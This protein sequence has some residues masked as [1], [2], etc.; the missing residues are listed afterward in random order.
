MMRGTI[1]DI[2]H[3]LPPRFFWCPLPEL[4]VLLFEGLAHL[5][6]R[7]YLHINDNLRPVV[8]GVPSKLHEV[9]LQP[10]TRNTP[11]ALPLVGPLVLGSDDLITGRSGRL[12]VFP[13]LLVGDQPSLFEDVVQ[14]VVHD[15]VVPGIDFNAHLPAPTYDVLRVPS[16]P[17]LLQKH[18]VSA[19]FFE[20]NFF[21]F[22][23]QRRFSWTSL[24]TFMVL[25]EQLR[26]LH[27]F[28]NSPT[29][30]LLWF[31]MTFFR[32]DEDFVLVNWLKRYASIRH[33]VPFY[34]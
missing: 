8:I 13:L 16:C 10:C 4:V 20:I 18:S 9:R 6:S 15:D 19:F 32:S 3:I 5:V 24:I 21:L 30:I 33:G 28:L 29:S 17:D 14:E 27:V 22:P 7:R 26:V 31:S 11:P 2:I 12:P 25:G 1:T 23:I 34:F